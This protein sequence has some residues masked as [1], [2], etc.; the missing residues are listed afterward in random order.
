MKP[1]VRKHTSSDSH[2]HI[3]AHRTNRFM[4]L[5]NDMKAR[6][7]P[8][9]DDQ[10]MWA[11]LMRVRDPATGLPYDD[12]ITA[13][14]IG[15]AFIAGFHTTAYSTMCVCFVCVCVACCSLSCPQ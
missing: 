4:N 12:K 2:T 15:V 8:P 10:R 11:S 3:H 6:G 14:N 1:Q 5:L 9:P 13:A 7:T